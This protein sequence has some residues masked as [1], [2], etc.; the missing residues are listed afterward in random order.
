MSTHDAWDLLRQFTDARIALGRS[1][2]S[3]PTREVLK[4]GLAHAQARDAIHQP[5]DSEPLRGELEA[6]GL[7]TLTVHS[8]AADRDTYLHRPDLGRRL[9]EESRALLARRKGNA[10]LLLVIGDGLSSH[11]VH[12]QSVGLIRA[13]LPYIE[14]LGL[15]LAPVALAH[16][17][18]VALG[19]DIGEALGAK[20]VAIL[21][22]ERP[23]LSSPDSLGVYLTWKPERSRIESERNCISNIR[24][25]GLPW[26][27]AA[28]K[29]AWLLEQA[30][31]R[32]LTGV[33]LKDESDNPALHGKVK[34][35]LR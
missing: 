20:A 30:F 33:K 28:F 4:F 29:L 17:S 5:F 3:L 32:R 11:A 24:P 21:I 19:D 6:L 2:A 26:E 35:L 27:A 10:D 31:L 7:E 18:R 22:G 16:Q 8:A 1:G 12:R 23:G 15:T 13:L 25:E 14:T 9:D 34:P